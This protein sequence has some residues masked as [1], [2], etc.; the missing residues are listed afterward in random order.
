[1]TEHG[2]LYFVGVFEKEDGGALRGSQKDMSMRGTLEGI[3]DVV[4]LT[5]LVVVVLELVV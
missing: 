3:W 5:C 4:Q 1:M 2:G